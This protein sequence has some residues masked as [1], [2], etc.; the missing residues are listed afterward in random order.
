MV[1]AIV[2]LIGLMAVFSRRN[3]RRESKEKEQQLA[4][5]EDEAIKAMYQY[6]E[7]VRRKSAIV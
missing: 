7:D 3:A 5:Q 2:L 1:G 4:R 6:Q